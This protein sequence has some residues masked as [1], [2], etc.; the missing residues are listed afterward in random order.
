MIER[1]ACSLIEQTRLK[2]YGPLLES[3]M[4]MK[5]VAKRCQG[6]MLM[7]LK[8]RRNIYT[9]PDKIKTDERIIDYIKNGADS[10]S[11]R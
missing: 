4:R 2:Y 1:N 11:F 7:S 10:A 9:C 8:K 5:V 3:V 6:N